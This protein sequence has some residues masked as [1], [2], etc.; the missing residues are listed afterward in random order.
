MARKSREDIIGQ[1][2]PDLLDKAWRAFCATGEQYDDLTTMLASAISAVESALV[3][4]ELNRLMGLAKKKR[5]NA[6][7]EELDL[8]VSWRIRELEAGRGNE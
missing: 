4:A 5:L 7:A 1:V 6:Q 2:D 3:L 8:Q